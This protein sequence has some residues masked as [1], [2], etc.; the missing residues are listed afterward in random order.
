MLDLD[1]FKDFNDRYGHM[2]LTKQGLAERDR[3]VLAFERDE[4]LDDLLRLGARL[5]VARQ[6]QH[7]DG[8]A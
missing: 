2:A 3:Q 5:G 6:E 8:M 4:T 1:R 7:A